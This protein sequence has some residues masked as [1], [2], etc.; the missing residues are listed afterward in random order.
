[1]SNP[2]WLW[3]G[4]GACDCSKASLTARMRAARAAGDRRFEC[5]HGLWLGCVVAAGGNAVEETP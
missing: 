1:M 2:D 3:T 4:P 5:A